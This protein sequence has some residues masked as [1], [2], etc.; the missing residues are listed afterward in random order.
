MGTCATHRCR[1]P[2]SYF[3]LCLSRRGLP[4]LNR[5]ELVQNNKALQCSD[6]TSTWNS[7]WK[8]FTGNDGGGRLSGAVQADHN[9]LTVKS[10]SNWV[11]FCLRPSTGQWATG[12]KYGDA[13]IGQETRN[14][15]FFLPALTMV[16]YITGIAHQAKAQ[17]SGARTTCHWLLAILRMPKLTPHYQTPEI[18]CKDAPSIV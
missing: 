4:V 11:P 14:C 5:V 12:L 9:D 18:H 10:S 17:D 8:A 2:R 16:P 3:S 15:S 13:A 7:T 1:T 6:A